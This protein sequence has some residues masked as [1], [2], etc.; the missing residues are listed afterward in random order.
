MAW[1]ALA[2]LA[3]G[4]AAILMIRFGVRGRWPV[5]WLA[6][7]LNLASRAQRFA[8]AMSMLHAGVYRISRGRLL[9][10]WFGMPV[11]VIETRG[12]KSGRIRR[13]TIVYVRDRDDVIVTPANAGAD[14]TPSWWLNLIAA[15]EGT[16]VLGGERRRVCPRIA[17]SAERER[18]WGKLLRAGPAIAEYQAYTDRRFPVAVLQAAGA[19]TSGA[20]ARTE[21][22][23]VA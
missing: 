6:R 12:R 7:T 5:R 19:H 10:W 22:E 3:I 4:I 8:R 23:R 9:D 14:K 11:L 21:S 2:L 17:Q 13:T 15:G 18:L 1:I 20:V 16:V